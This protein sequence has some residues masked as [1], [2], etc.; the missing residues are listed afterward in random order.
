MQ[1]GNVRIKRGISSELQWLVHNS[2]L[3]AIIA[4]WSSVELQHLINKSQTI[5]LIVKYFDNEN[6]IA[7][8]DLIPAS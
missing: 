6:K 5:K 8:N 3:F 1:T 2:N 4:I 7:K